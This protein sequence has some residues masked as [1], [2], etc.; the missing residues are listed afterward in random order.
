MIKTAEVIH[1]GQYKA[2]QRSTHQASCKRSH[3][4][5]QQ[6]LA[7]LAEEYLRIRALEDRGNRR[8]QFVLWDAEIEAVAG[9]V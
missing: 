9:R 4:S 6:Q 7:E 8:E 3:V 5:R 2:K 1:L